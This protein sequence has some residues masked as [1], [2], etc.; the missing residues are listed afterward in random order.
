M[1]LMKYT[2]EH[3]TTYYHNTETCQILRLGKNEL[4][5][6]HTFENGT[7]RFIQN[8]SD[9]VLGDRIVFLLPD[10]EWLRTTNVVKIEDLGEPHDIHPYGQGSTLED[11]DD[12]DY[13]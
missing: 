6:A 4:P 1:T 3:G 5:G 10:S 7:W 8:H 2:T 13:E 11:G 12:A 9:I